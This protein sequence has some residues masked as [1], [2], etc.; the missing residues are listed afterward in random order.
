MNKIQLGIKVKTFIV[1][2]KMEFF[3]RIF[4][5]FVNSRS[6]N[7][8]GQCNL[9]P[10]FIHIVRYLNFGKSSLKLKKKDTITTLYFLK[11]KKSA[12]RKSNQMQSPVP[13]CHVFVGQLGLCSKVD[14][15][16]NKVQLYLT[17]TKISHSRFNFI[18]PFSM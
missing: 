18:F 4:Y 11:L 17:R 6:M 7:G 9:I 10:S 13:P 1:D 12:I 5:T 3:I 2:I 8:T 15:P 16:S 14:K